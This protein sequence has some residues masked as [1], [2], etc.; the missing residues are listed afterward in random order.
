MNQNF[1]SPEEL[2]EDSIIALGDDHIIIAIDKE[3]EKLNDLDVEGH[4]WWNRFR[5]FV[6][7]H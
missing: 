4:V 6:I 1:K 7:N 5:E 2:H 3:I